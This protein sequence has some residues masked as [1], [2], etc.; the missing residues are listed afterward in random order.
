VGINGFGRIGRL[1]LRAAQNHPEIEVG[2][3]E[4]LR[5]FFL[6]LL[7]VYLV[8]LLSYPWNVNTKAYSIISLSSPFSLPSL[9]CDHR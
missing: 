5:L 2:Y 9:P 8:A 7:S 6:C 3:P 1:V 4:T